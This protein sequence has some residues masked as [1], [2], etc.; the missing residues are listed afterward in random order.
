MYQ[1]GQVESKKKSIDAELQAAKDTATAAEARATP[2]SPA[3]VLL[4]SLELSLKYEPSSE[5]L[6][7]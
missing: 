2:A 1:V 5:P 7:C 6:H 3:F 4:S